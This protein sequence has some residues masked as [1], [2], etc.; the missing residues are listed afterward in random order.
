MAIST[1]KPHSYFSH[2]VH[3]SCIRCCPLSSASHVNKSFN[4]LHR[5]RIAHLFDISPKW[6]R[7]KNSTHLKLAR[8]RHCFPLAEVH[9][10]SCVLLA[11]CITNGPVNTVYRSKCRYH[12]LS[13]GS[14][15]AFYQTFLLACHSLT[16]CTYSLFHIQRTATAAAN[17]NDDDDRMVCIHPTSEYLLFVYA[18][19]QLNITTLA[20]CNGFWHPNK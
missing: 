6:P 8:N 1:E 13:N 2:S 16:L 20:D 17:T 11:S 4:P 12:M 10:S 19:I 14:D 15:E 18:F 9:C 5:M 3:F 7:Q